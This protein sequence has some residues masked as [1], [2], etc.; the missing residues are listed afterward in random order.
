VFAAPLVALLVFLSA[1]AVAHVTNADRDVLAA[2]TTLLFAT[3]NRKDNS[4]VERIAQTAASWDAFRS[5]PIMGTGPGKPIVWLD[6]TNEVH[7]STTVDSSVSFLAKF[8]LVGLVAAGFLVVGYVGTM[9]A[10][11]ARTRAPT[12]TQLALVGFGAVAGAWSL[13]LNPY[14]DKGFAIALILLLTVAARE[15]SDAVTRVGRPQRDGSHAG[16]A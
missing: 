9:R 12:I 5:S 14:E 2:R 10:L 7:L 16:A 11:R 4:Y 15:A 1:Q 6:Y 13:V 3:G 8:G